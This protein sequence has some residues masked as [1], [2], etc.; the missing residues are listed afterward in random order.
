[1]VTGLLL[2]P[3]PALAQYCGGP[4]AEVF[5][6]WG[7]STYFRSIEEALQ[8]RCTTQWPGTTLRVVLG[9]TVPISSTE[10]YGNNW[11]G[12]CYK[13]P[14]N[15]LPTS[16]QCLPTGFGECGP[17]PDGSERHT[18]S[19]ARVFYCDVSVGGPGFCRIN[20]I[21]QDSVPRCMVASH[22]LDPDLN[23][24]NS[25]QVCGVS[26]GSMGG[27][28]FPSSS[29][30]GG[31]TQGNPISPQLAEKTQVEQDIAA[32]GGLGFARTYRSS[33]PEGKATVRPTRD[34][35]R[36]WRHSLFRAIDV[37]H[38]NS[39]QRQFLSG[40][41]FSLT[42]LRPDG[43]ALTY[44]RVGSGWVAQSGVFDTL[45]DRLN[46]SGIHIGWTY[47]EYGRGTVEL[48]DANGDIESVTHP[49]GAS[50]AWTRASGSVT[51]TNDQGR[52]LTMAMT[53]GRIDSVTDGAG[54]T[55]NYTYDSNGN[56]VTVEYPDGEERHYHYNETTLNGGT[57]RPHLL[58]GITDEDGQRYASFGYDSAGKAIMTTHLIG[59]TEVDKFQFSYVAPIPGF[60]GTSRA[61]VIDPMGTT[62]QY[63]FANV[64]GVARSAGQ[65][66]P[67][68]AG[69][70]AAA[71]DINHDVSGN[72]TSR[73]DFNGNT[74]C[75]KV[76]TTRRLET[77]R[78]EGLAPSVGCPSNLVTHTP[79]SKQ[80][81][82]TQQ[83]HPTLSLVERRAEPNRLV[84]LVYNGRPDPSNGGATASCASGASTT[85][86]CKRI[87]TATTDATGANGLSATT[88]GSSRI[89][90]WT[91][92]AQGR[93]LT[94]DG[95]RTDVADITTYTYRAA[96]EAACATQPTTCAYRKG[97]LWRTTNALGQVSEVLAY[98]GAGR[99]LSVLDANGVRTDFEYTPR[100]WLSRRLLRGTDDNSEADDQ[101]T[102]FEYEPYGSINKV[103]QPDGSFLRYHYDAAHRLTGISDAA[104]DRIDYA[105][106]A[107]GNRLKE[108]TKDPNGNVKR[109]LARQFDALSR[110]RSQISA[111]FAAMADLDDPA[112]KKTRFEYDPNGNHTRVTDALDVAT[113]ND[114]DALNRLIRSIGDH[115]AG[116]INATSLFTYDARDNLRT[117]TDPKGL[118]TTYT[119]DGLDNL[120]QLQSPDTGTTSY[121]HDAAGNR[122]SQTDARGV[123]STYTYDALGRMTGVSFSDRGKDL[124][125]IYD[126]AGTTCRAG[127]GFAT[128]RLSRF[129]DETGSTE[130]CYDRRGQLVRRTSVVSGETYELTWGYDGAGRLNSLTYPSGTVVAYAR[131]NRGRI[132]G[133]DVTPANAS[134]TTL[135]S[136]VA[137]LPFGPIG[138]IT[139]GDQS[140]L[141]RRYDQ[142]YWIDQIESSHPEGLVLDFSTD[143]VGNIVSLSDT[144]APSV[145]VDSYG[146]DDLY[147]L[148][149]QDSAVSGLTQYGYD[150]T[151]NRTGVT[152]ASSATAYAYPPGSHR[153]QAV[154]ASLRGYDANGNTT[155]MNGRTLSYDDR[156]RLTMV[157]LG[158]GGSVE[159]S[160]NARG[161]RVLRL[162]DS[163]GTAT[164]T[165]YVYD[166]AG[167][168][169]LEL[170]SKKG[171][172]ASEIVW[173]DDLPV[174][175]ID[176]SG[177]VRPI[178]PD[179]LGSPR[180][181]IEPSRGTALWDWPILGDA[182]GTAAANDDPDGDGN[183]TTLNL[184]FPGQQYDAATGLHYN[185]FR[186]YDPA[187][188]RYVESDP[189][190]LRG[191]LNTFTYVRSRPVIN[192]DPQGLVEWSGTLGGGAAIDVVGGSILSFDL[193]SE[194]KCNRRVR[195]SGY[196]SFLAGGFGLKYTGSGASTSFTD[197]FECPEETAPNGSAFMLGVAGVLGAG[198]SCSYVNLGGL[199]S[200]SCGPSFGIDISAGM[201][202]GA[203]VVTTAKTECCG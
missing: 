27:P 50:L 26:G 73:T 66:Q 64:L 4:P 161:E 181:V 168:L 31:N 140:T 100:G 23:D 45:V 58:T 114:H 82:I 62:R 32:A 55:V 70:S 148:T 16:P 49:S 43:R 71:S 59:S 90:S 9:P 144:L 89:S 103:T 101:I 177:E 115:G 172:S 202:V 7:T 34:L 129:T 178:E 169:L 142:N 151:G 154:G 120:T 156:N 2:S 201:Y 150:A 109:L 119:Y 84:D 187:T 123:T 38:P 98:D 124:G 184:R 35:G 197:Y 136:D 133:I 112:V 5:W 173:L 88:T 199:Y 163:F 52:S 10:P 47:T 189:I 116:G 175:L 44:A 39:T 40:Q 20:G 41:V 170:P 166:E 63:D 97:D 183:A 53:D 14:T 29:S 51:V 69:C 33:M 111:P 104:G 17:A 132:V 182:F 36:Y 54:D 96:D 68:G 125:F 57:S 198:G 203:S 22:G 159:S 56:L 74:T 158:I 92:D 107:A 134:A 21:Q 25:P 13:E 80:R 86:L 108:E 176:K 153:L 147:R 137:Y 87:E 130:F 105:L 164:E 139:W 143:L 24:P 127:E 186:D 37:N 65:S 67:G 75:Y 128:G 61:T 135:I 121:T 18:A 126:E 195:V 81:K 192:V 190:G 138:T 106:D 8:A 77:V 165:R 72:V 102:A 145:P 15:P 99:A 149:T 83:W 118:V 76:D 194:C 85:V 60:A 188:G 46:G 157:N 6:G 185:Y 113:D 191:G 11:Q 131:D 171:A 167:R 200:S 180:K 162:Q 155:S 94:A 122:I 28:G 141:A 91:Y 146:Y 160:Y 152:T 95:P 93:V 193:V 30:D 179:H 12:I 174:G 110:M 42:M 48:Y 79:V 78:L 196:A 1:M 3:L 117:V 19:I